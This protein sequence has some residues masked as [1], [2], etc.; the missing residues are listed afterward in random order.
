MAR[1]SKSR[2]KGRRKRKG[3]RKPRQGRWLRRLLYISFLA[4][5]GTAALSVLVILPLRWLNPATTAFI[6]A[7]D[8][9]VEPVRYEWVDWSELGD[10]AP[11]A[12]IASED[13]R[14]AD[15]AGL[16]FKAIHT[17]VIE[18]NERGYLRGASTISQQT[19]KNLFLW[20]G[21]SFAR[22][23]L[24]AWL[25]LVLE[26]CLPKKRILEIYL[27][28]A[29]FGPGIYGAGAASERFFGRP[30]ARISD[31]EAALLAAVLPNP[32]QLSVDAP[33]DYV[34]ER[35]AWILTQMA[36]LRREAWLTR[37]TD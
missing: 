13:Q 16:D 3:K 25:T 26:S 2:R 21:R 35:Q 10:A 22:K 28:I 32:R 18:Q 19:A 7:D 15:H 20:P 1:R 14:F 37:L 36:R 27:N 23:A 33:S 24:E 11:L 9:G 34:R 12:V 29:E 17:A 31:R 6:L 30:P 4:F 8:S 5:L